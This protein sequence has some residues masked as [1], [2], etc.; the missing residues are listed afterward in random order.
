MT[1]LLLA[2]LSNKQ[3]KFID[4]ATQIADQLSW[5]NNYKHGCV[6]VK[7]GQIV[8][9]GWNHPRTRLRHNNVGSAHAETHAIFSLYRGKYCGLRGS[10]VYG[11]E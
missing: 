7:N 11:L 5:G 10:K 2:E 6:L 8:S 3:Q 9:E 1:K 4:R